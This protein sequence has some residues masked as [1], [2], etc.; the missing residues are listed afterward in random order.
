MAEERGYDNSLN[1]SGSPA[2][3]R[4][5]GLALQPQLGAV[6]KRRPWIDASDCR[7]PPLVE[8]DLK[9][10]RSCLSQDSYVPCGDLD[11]PFALD[12][13][14]ATTQFRCKRHEKRKKAA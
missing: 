10:G 4:N 6:P 14:S 9:S 2:D 5:P 8:S 13:E 7:H 12:C 11:A 1:H 3:W